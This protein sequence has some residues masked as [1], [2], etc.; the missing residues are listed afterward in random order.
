MQFW[1]P[2]PI[3]SRDR[4]LMSRDS[5]TGKSVDSLFTMYWGKQQA[6]GLHS[7]VNGYYL[8]LLFFVREY[9]QLLQYSNILG[10]STYPNKIKINYQTKLS[11]NN[12]PFIIYSKYF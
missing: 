2:L 9:S 1:S 10:E 8:L 7:H 4:S 5:L 11:V 12:R 3:L 6:E